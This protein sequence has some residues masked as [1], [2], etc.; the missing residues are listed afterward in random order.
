MGL[1]RVHTHLALVN[2]GYENPI[3]AHLGD[4]LGVLLDAFSDAPPLLNHDNRRRT[5][6]AT[7]QAG[8]LGAHLDG[9]EC[10]QATRS[11][12]SEQ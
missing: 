8:Y 7:N 2:I 10:R 3:A 1:L 5:R 4:F 12:E 6:W 9:S 11:P